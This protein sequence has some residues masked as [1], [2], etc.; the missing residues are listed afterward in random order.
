MS[1]IRLRPVELIVRDN[2]VTLHPPAQCI[3]GNAGAP[4][5][6][7][8]DVDPGLNVAEYPFALVVFVQLY[9]T[10]RHCLA[11]AELSQ[12]TQRLMG[13]LACPPNAL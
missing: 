9:L 12:V 3:Y 2:H 1:H 4:Y 5:G 7:A 10:K 13:L 6:Y 8:R 11:Q